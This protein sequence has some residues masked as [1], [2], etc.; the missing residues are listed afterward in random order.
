MGY[1]FTLDTSLN[2]LV[3]ELS[4]LLE[5]LTDGTPFYPIVAVVFAKHPLVDQAHYLDY[6]VR[7]QKLHLLQGVLQNKLGD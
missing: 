6:V 4:I 2:M 5:P 1:S 7:L 3:A